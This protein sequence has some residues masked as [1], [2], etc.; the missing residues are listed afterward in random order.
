MSV[1]QADLDWAKEYCGNIG[2]WY[3]GPDPIRYGMTHED[4]DEGRA[5]LDEAWSIWSS[6]TISYVKV[7]LVT[8]AGYKK[9]II[10][11]QIWRDCTPLE[12]KGA[13]K[14]MDVFWRSDLLRRGEMHKK[15]HFTM[16][17]LQ[18]RI[19]EDDT[20][21]RDV[22]PRCGQADGGLCRLHAAHPARVSRWSDCRCVCAGRGF[23]RDFLLADAA[24][25]ETRCA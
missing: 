7:M 24:P 6:F 9:A 20:A 11:A 8:L 16:S 5:L 18:H 15:R 14:A 1:T 10:D 4:P 12:A 13:H 23:R 17:G 22:F 21:N 19:L 2:R 3:T 25:A